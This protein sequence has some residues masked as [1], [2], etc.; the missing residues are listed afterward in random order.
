MP[1]AP[2]GGLPLLDA[3]TEIQSLF[4]RDASPRKLFDALLD[5]LLRAT[6]SAYG[7]VGEVL[8]D[9][10]GAPYLKT[11]A[12]TNIAWDDTTRA[13]YRRFEREGLEFRNLDTLFGL[14]LTSGQTVISNDPEGDTRRGGIPRGHP[15]LD[16]F[17][18]LPVFSGGEM[19]GLI[20]LANRPGGY[21][22]ALADWL[23][24]LVTATGQIVAAF[25]SERERRA[26]LEALRESESRYRAILETAAEAI[27]TIDER[28]IIEDFNP[29]AER[30]FGYCRAEVVGQNV[31]LLMDEPHR[32]AHDGYVDRYLATGHARI[33]GIGREVSGRRKDG[34]LFPMELAIAE[35]KLAHG[36]RFS[37]IVRDVSERQRAGDE[38]RRLLAEFQALFNLSPDGFVTFDEAGCLKYANPAFLRMCGCEAESLA[39]LTQ[40]DFE[41]RMAAMCDPAYPYTPIAE[42]DEAVGDVLRRSEPRL[43]IVRRSMRRLRGEDARPLGRALYF[44][45]ITHESELDRM[46]TEFLSTAAHELRTPLASIHGFSELLLKRDFDADTR[47]DLLQTIHR[48]ST[49]LAGL[50][51]ELLDLARIEARAGKDFRIEAQPLLPIVEATLRH[52]MVPEDPR[53]VALRIAAALPDVRVDAAKLEQALLNVLSN[54]YKYSPDGGAIELEIFVG[55][56]GEEVGIAVRDHGI[57]MTA[58]EV[59]QVCERF[60]RAD[61]SGAIPGTGL[62]MSLVEEIMTILGGRIAIDSRPGRGTAVTLWLP[63]VTT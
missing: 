54:A 41:A 4:I 50:V 37:G 12:L 59:G 31:S 40:A 62:G 28:G 25:R 33:I 29:A 47:R 58:D 24:P 34:E 3:I 9:E 22:D 39:G 6:G 57:G 15:P 16:A 60:F 53:R 51:N 13:L 42:L 38:R 48:Q 52:L 44:Q 1:F 45:D 49:N 43:T 36:R 32:S 8:R 5:T 46:K 18:G 63:A 27:I 30:I 55:E 56:G 2:S 35:V 20:G 11:F 17:L 19:V 7:F 21:E 26:A 14:A 23:A 61:S 10:G